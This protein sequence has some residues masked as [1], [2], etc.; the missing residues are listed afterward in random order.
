MAGLKA[1]LRAIPGLVPAYRN[2]RS[3][4]E[5]YHLRRRPAQAVFTDIFRNNAWNGS[6][7]VSGT[8]SDPEQ[9]R[10]LVRVLPPLLKDLDV[11]TLLDIPCGD[12]HW[13][14]DVDLAGIRYTGGDIVP[15]LAQ[16][17]QSTYGD[18]NRRF[19]HLDLL[20]GAL[21]QADL[22][23]CRDCLVHLSFTDIALALANLRASGSRY[24]LTTTFPQR[25]GNKDIA[26]GQWRPLNLQA[27]PF[28]LPA[29]LQ[30]INEQCT[31]EGGVHGDKSLG[32]WLIRDIR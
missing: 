7:S 1:W 31:E 32:L 26:T 21:P 30:L 3:R 13:M 4:W 15:E 29:P 22:V 6:G 17:N 19:V 27:P 28:S 14:R 2:L 12:F 25:S 9:T 11:H 10:V 16:R 20:R 18:E 23:F 5:A 8:G 24:L